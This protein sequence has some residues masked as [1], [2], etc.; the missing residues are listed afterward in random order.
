MSLSVYFI[1]LPCIVCAVFFSV[2]L[3]RRSKSVSHKLVTA[4]SFLSAVA[5]FADSCIVIDDVSDNLLNLSELLRILSVPILLPLFNIYLVSLSGKMDLRYGRYALMWMTV[6][7]ALFTCTLLILAMGLKD[8]RIYDIVCIYAFKGILLIEIITLSI[9][10]I[11]CMKISGFGILHYFRYLFAETEA[12]PKDVQTVNIFII[13]CLCVFRT[14]MGREWGI[15]HEWISAVL[16]LVISQAF[17]HLY[18]TAPLSELGKIRFKMSFT[19][20][21]LANSE[22]ENVERT[23]LASYRHLMEKEEFFRTPG[24]TIGMIAGKLNT[25]SDI[26]AAIVK[27]QYKTTFPAHI[28]NMRVQFSKR[29][30]KNHPGAKMS[31]VADECGYDSAQSFCRAFKN[32]E[33]L[34]P[35][36]WLSK[37]K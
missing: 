36:Q 26:V 3:L 14:A 17:L 7:L 18:L 2:F 21:T 35:G 5:L 27:G 19:P 24:I 32:L 30:I 34:S 4:I 37:N 16:F 8:S 22:E 23:V 13:F 33:G 15:E 6:P 9:Y 31:E 11:R 12:S 10:L 25:D 1:I 20:M 28:N 29:Y